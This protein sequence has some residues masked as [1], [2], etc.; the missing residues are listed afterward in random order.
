MLMRM[1]MM[2]RC[3][4]ALTLLRAPWRPY[5]SLQCPVPLALAFSGNPSPPTGSLS[6][7]SSTPVSSLPRPQV[8]EP[9]VPL[10][11]TF[12]LQIRVWLTSLLLTGLCS[13]VISPGSLSLNAL[14]N[15]LFL[16][17]FMSQPYFMFLHHA[18]HSLNIIMYSYL[19]TC[20]LAVFP[21][22]T[23]DFVHLPH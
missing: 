10:T 22:T 8:L 14:S 15:S 23:W 6:D 1:W 13:N 9:A 4:S 19:W 3:C 18:Y 2:S 17:F 16:S 11:S 21:V 7:Y 12:F 5:Q 20:F